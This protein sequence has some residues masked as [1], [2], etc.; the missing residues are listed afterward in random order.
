M[1]LVFWSSFVFLFMG[2]ICTWKI[3]WMNSNRFCLMNPI[4]ISH[5]IN[6]SEE[7]YNIN[8]NWPDFSQ[9]IGQ[10]TSSWGFS[11]RVVT[12][13]KMEDSISIVFRASKGRKTLNANCQAPEEPSLLTNCMAKS[14]LGWER[15]FHSLW[16]WLW[17]TFSIRNTEKE[18]LSLMGREVD[19]SNQL[20][21]SLSES[22]IPF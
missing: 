16:L 9:Y 7:K 3:D 21:P 14:S 13:L 12:S 5:W 1:N 8:N 18:M 11:V 20:G 10:K 22:S 2:S 4:D 19:F 6:Q 17:Q 15:W